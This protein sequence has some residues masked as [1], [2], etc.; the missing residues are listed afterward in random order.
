MTRELSDRWDASLAPRATGRRGNGRREV[1]IGV[2]TYVGY[3]AVR[4]LVWTDAGRCRAVRNAGRLAALERRLHID[5]EP[6]LQR[7]ALRWPRLVDALNAGYAAG[8]VGLTVGW[9][10]LLFGRGDPSFR[11]ERRAAVLAFAGALPIFALF[12]AAP[13]R[14]L[15]GFVDTLAARGLSL[16]HPLLVRFYNPIAAFP[17]HHVAFSVVTGTALARRAGGPLRRA[18]WWSYPAAVTLVVLATANH[19]VVDAAAGAALGV[20]ARATASRLGR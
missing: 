7:H 12:P 8:N 10:L 14:A 19:F 18:G 4:R 13:P 1:A 5:V 9:L 3:L 16:D 11:M 15:D 20:A 17:S 2:G 6:R